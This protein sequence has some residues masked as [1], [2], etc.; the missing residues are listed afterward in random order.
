MIKTSL[1]RLM[2]G[3]LPLR[4]VYYYIQGTLRYRLYYSRFKFLIRKHIL[5]QI[6]YRINVMNYECYERGECVL[7]GCST[8]ALQMCNKS[9]E[10]KE[11]P[12]MMGKKHWSYKVTSYHGKYCWIWDPNLKRFLTYKLNASAHYVLYNR[13]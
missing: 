3:E 13:D 12:I 2:R 8:T 10:G 9:C 7:C 5:E 4:D 11:Y 1:L 6:D